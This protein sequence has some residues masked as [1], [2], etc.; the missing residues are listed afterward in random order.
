MTDPQRTDTAGTVRLLRSREDRVIAGVCG[1]VAR[2]L[3]VDP[4]LLRIIAV[5]LAFYGGVGLLLYALAWLLLPEDEQPATLL[6]QAFGGERRAADRST[7]TVALAIGL[8]IFAL[9]SALA[10]VNSSWYASVLLI[11]TALGLYLL[12]QR[13]RGSGAPRVEAPATAVQPTWTHP[14]GTPLGRTPPTGSAA[15]STFDAGT[16]P[17]DAEEVSEEEISWDPEHPWGQQSSPGHSMPPPVDAG[18]GAP[19]PPPPPEQPRKD[20][21][22]LF[23]L[24]LSVA[25]LALGALWIA[26]ASG[27]EVPGPTYVATALAVVGLGLLIG[28]WLGRARGLIAV[29]I[30]LSMVLAGWMVVPWAWTF[31][32]ENLVLRPVSAQQ[33]SGDYDHSV[34]DIRYDLSDVDFTGEHAELNIN[35]GIGRVTVELPPDVDVSARANVGVGTLTVLDGSSDGLGATRSLSDV[36]VDGP[37]GGSLNLRIE[38]GVGEV[39]VTRETA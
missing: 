31:R 10:V 25:L 15:T 39:V 1:G 35:H 30:V 36:G 18:W 11:G 6:E 19:M 32:G 27:R 8:V 24:T 20:R 9:V 13:D 5:V 34:G 38:L 17:S 14:T 28:A 23:M 26:D 37:G 7:G 22:A 21:S 2:Q 12:L 3:R 29:G 16:P 33:V 4:V